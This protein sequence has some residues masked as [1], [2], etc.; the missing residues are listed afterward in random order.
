MIMPGST[1]NTYISEGSLKFKHREF[2]LDGKPFKLLSGAFHYFRV[3]P[4]YWTDRLLKI[5]A[6]GLN[7]V[8]T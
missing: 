2:S 4:E 3:L 6:C 5:K 8:E 1:D 7:T